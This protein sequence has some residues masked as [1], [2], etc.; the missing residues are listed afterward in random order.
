MWYLASSDRR[1]CEQVPDS[2]SQHVAKQRRV[3]SCSQKPLILLLL[4]AELQQLLPTLLR[5]LQF[6]FGPFEPCQSLSGPVASSSCAD[7]SRSSTAVYRAFWKT[8][9]ELKPQNPTP[10]KWFL[11]A[12]PLPLAERA[13]A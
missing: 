2:R 10:W 12:A 3:K 1:I 6:H 7:H 13:P 4:L 11:P 5:E 8:W 9:G